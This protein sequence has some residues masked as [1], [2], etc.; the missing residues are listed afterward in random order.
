MKAADMTN[1][2]HVT[3]TLTDSAVEQSYQVNSALLPHN[4]TDSAV[5][6][7]YQV[8]S[9]LLPNNSTDS[10]VE[11]SY[12]VNSVQVL[13]TSAQAELLETSISEIHN[14]E[15]T[16]RI[17]G[18]SGRKKRTVS[19]STILTCSPY[20]TMLEVDK[21]KKTV[22]NRRRENSAKKAGKLMGRKMKKV[23]QQKNGGMDIRMERTFQRK[24]KKNS[25]KNN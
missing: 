8:N 11:H 5:E 14:V 24:Q 16:L 20:E 13:S 18:E 1:K 15:I 10:A 17:H 25:Q 9:D 2:S 23:S 22:L 19:H 12:Q 3:S 6:Q 4:S 21:E 7:P